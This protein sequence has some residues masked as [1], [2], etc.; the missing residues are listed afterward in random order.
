MPAFYNWSIDL[1]QRKAL[2]PLIDAVRAGD[3]VL[4]Y[5]CGVGRWSRALAR[6]GATVTGVDF[7]G[8]MLAQA[9][10]R[11]AAAGLA[12]FCDFVE[13]DVTAL[14]LGRR[15]DIVIGVTV[16]QHVL[17]EDRLRAAANRLA[18][19]LEPG[20]RLIMLEAAPCEPRACAETET[21]RVRT[22]KAYVAAIEAAG[23]TIEAIRGVD[24]LPFKLWVVPRFRRWPRP[25]AIA[26]LLIATL[27]SLPLDLLLAH[28]LRERSWHK[29]LVARA[30]GRAS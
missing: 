28:R 25:F 21:F 15:F 3:R 9:R 1:T 17:G 12:P 14:E 22:L 16:L 19:H 26:A 30:P 23:L 24:P 7:S 6:R 2:R 13:S 18:Q 27:C 10:A 5:G 20:G 29:I 4:D 8:A 11:T